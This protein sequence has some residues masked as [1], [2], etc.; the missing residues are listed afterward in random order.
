VKPIIRHSLF[1]F[2][3][4]AI[5]ISALVLTTMSLNTKKAEL[6]TLIGAVDLQIALF[7]ETPKEALLSVTLL[8]FGDAALERAVGAASDHYDRKIAPFVS[9][10]TSSDAA[11]DRLE[12]A[13][14]L[15]EA[16]RNKARRFPAEKETIFKETESFLRLAPQLKVSTLDLAQMMETR[17]VPWQTV[18]DAR[19]QVELV[20]RFVF[21]AAAYMADGGEPRYEELKK[22]IETYSQTL[23]GFSNT[24][25]LQA[26]VLALVGTNQLFW[27]GYQES[28]NAA[29]E[30]RR[31][32]IKEIGEI[33]LESEALSAELNAAK[34]EIKKAGSTFLSFMSLVQASIALLLAAAIGYAICLF[35]PFRVEAPSSKRLPVVKERAQEDDAQDEETQAL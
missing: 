8:Q 22:T 18:Q 13:K 7:A 21:L 6:E 29:I 12:S 11:A 25:N 19:K 1:V 9:P 26:S 24:D 23:Y 27:K 34:N 5:L 30:T 16:L 14:K 3:L 33:Y 15:W 2:P 28:L 35:V 20:E 32:T 31:K 10:A 4:I 17:R